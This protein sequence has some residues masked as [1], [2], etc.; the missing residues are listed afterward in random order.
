[1]LRIPVNSTTMRN[2]EWLVQHG[3]RQ[4][5]RRLAQYPDG[6]GI[7]RKACRSRAAGR[8]HL[9]THCPESFPKSGGHSRNWQSEEAG[10]GKIPPINQRGE[11]PRTSNATRHDF[12]EM[13]AVP[14]LSSLCGGQ[15][16]ADM[17][18]F[19]ADNEAFLRTIMPLLHGPPS[20]DSFPGCSGAWIR[21]RSGGH[22]R[23]S[24]KGGRRL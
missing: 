11:D 24:P 18:D 14:L 2:F 5:C 9:K 22:W 19:A 10:N 12:V 16:C 17:A 4:N 21:S 13:P 6:T 15:T 7:P 3:V 8:L 20:R 1:M 23:G